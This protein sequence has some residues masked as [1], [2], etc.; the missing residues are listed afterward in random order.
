MIFLGDVAH[1]FTGPAD[2]RSV[3]SNDAYIAAHHRLILWIK[4]VLS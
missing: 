1:P 4:K 3:D 2:W